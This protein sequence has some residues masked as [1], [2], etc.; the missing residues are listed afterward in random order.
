[1]TK[2]L[3]GDLFTPH[4]GNHYLIILINL[5]LEA[6]NEFSLEKLNA[7]RSYDNIKEID[8]MEAHQLSSFLFTVTISF[9]IILK[10]LE[11]DL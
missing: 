1:M 9:L 5:I 8:M 3:I 7:I 11:L 2:L 6:G 10:I 4:T